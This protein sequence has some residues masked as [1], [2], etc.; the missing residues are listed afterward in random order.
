MNR[1]LFDNRF[2]RELPGDP[3][4]GARIRQVHGALWSAV[5]P[6]PVAAPRVIAWSPEM[7]A[8]LGM[9]AADIAAPQFAQVF[10]GNALLDGMQPYAANYGGHQF[11]H[12]AGQLGDGRAITLGETINAAGE[13]WELQLKGAGPTPYSR[14]ADGRAVLRSSIREFLCSEAMHHLGVPTTRALCLLATGEEVVRD[15]FYDGHPRAEPGAI[16]C[17]VAPSFIRFGNF[18]LPA[19]RND[20]ALLRQ[21]ADFTIRR[22]YPELVGEG[23]TLYAGWFAQVCE[24]TAATIAHWMRV[25]F[26]HGVMNTDNLSI[27]GLTIDYGPYGWIDDYDPDWTPNTTDAHGRRYRFGWQPKIA[28]WN[29]GRLAQALSPLFASIEPLQAGLDGYAAAYTRADR[30]NVARKLGLATCR[31]EDVELIRDLHTLMHD[32]EADMTLLF[33]ALPDIDLATPTLAPLA[34]AFYDDDKRRHVEPAFIQW[35]SRYVARLRDDPLDATER[36]AR[37][38]AANPKYVLRNYLAQQAIDRAEQG[39]ESGI[40]ELLD[41]MRRPYDEQPGREAYAGKRPDWARDRAGCSML[42]CSS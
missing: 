15:M 37:M 24:R 25:G 32:G 1:L 3:E 12:W 29:L 36:R 23:E 42:S 21:L 19:S 4:Q 33:R 7:A 20:I 11:G 9:D 35:L 27:L 34:D 41:V 6:T 10:A 39:D 26:V 38:H 30:D 31:D 16:V 13:R 14:S 18:E 2:V 22:D 17:R 8:T 28:H 40:A 5:E